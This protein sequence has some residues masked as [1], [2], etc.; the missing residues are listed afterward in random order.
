M[1]KRHRGWGGPL[2]W[3]LIVAAVS[4]LVGL[5]ASKPHP[6][7]FVV[8][9]RS[10]SLAMEW[11]CA[12]QTVDWLLPPGAA[13]D[14]TYRTAA[15]AAYRPLSQRVA[16]ADGGGPQP[17]RLHLRAGALV[18]V[19]Q[20]PDGL[21]LISVRRS[22]RAGI[23]AGPVAELFPAVGDP[24]GVTDALSIRLPPGREP[25]A[26]PVRGIITAGGVLTQDGAGSDILLDG[27][28]IARGKP[29][30]ADETHSFLN[31]AVAAGSLIH[32]HPELLGP[33]AAA[34]PP[35]GWAQWCRPAVDAAPASGLMQLTFDEDGDPI[36]LSFIR[37]GP[38]V[39]L[40]TLGAA[41]PDDGSIVLLSVTLW[42]WLVSSAWAQTLIV[43]MAALLTML[44]YFYQA[45]GRRLQV[46]EDDP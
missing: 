20:G 17:G 24:V 35:A 36:A 25:M 9:A 7:S 45:G 16:G 26:L 12:D 6:V 33:Q 38:A 27:S 39:G 30:A 1:A 14:V 2:L 10:R 15:M 28:I 5:Y 13:A 11:P 4:A 40:Q 44:N 41:M 43:V 42:A 3:L 34:A 22:P 32:S 18:E 31:E 23:A 8:S 46:L 19:R 29:F 21:T 37:H